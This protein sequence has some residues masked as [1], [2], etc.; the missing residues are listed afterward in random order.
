MVLAIGVTNLCYMKKQ[1][2]RRGSVLLCSKNK[3]I[4]RKD[5]FQDKVTTV[6]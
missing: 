1:K 3:K 5:G 2:L 6:H 4:R